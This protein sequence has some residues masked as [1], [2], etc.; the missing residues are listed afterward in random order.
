MPFATSLLKQF[1]SNH[2]LLGRRFC[3]HNILQNLKLMLNFTINNRWIN[4]HCSIRNN[5]NR[6]PIIFPCCKGYNRVVIV[7]CDTV[8]TWS[9]SDKYSQKTPHSSNVRV[10]Y[11]V[12]FVNSASDLIFCLSSCNYL[13]NI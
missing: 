11:G 6:I 2:L 7:Q 1:L 13:H 12:S 5:I 3:L 8:I 4:A 10:R 9:F